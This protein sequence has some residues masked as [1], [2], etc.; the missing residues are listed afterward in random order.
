MLQEDHRIERVHG[1]VEQA[2]VVVRVGRS[3]DPEAG[4]HP[5]QADRVHGVLRPVAEPGADAAAHHDRQVGGVAVH[6][7]R[8]GELVEELVGGHQREV[9]EHDLHHH[10]HAQHGGAETEPGETALGDRGV[11]HA[12]REALDQPL[13]G[14]VGA[15]AQVGHLLAEDDRVRLPLQPAA[16][17][18]RDRVRVAHRL[19][20]RAVPGVRGTVVRGTVVRRTVDEA[21]AFQ[22]GATRA[23]AVAGRAGI[24]PQTLAHAR[25]VAFLRARRPRRLHALLGQC[26]DGLHRRVV[27]QAGLHQ[28][29]RQHARHLGAGVAV[30]LLL[31]A[32][33]EGAAGHVAGVVVAAVALALDDRRRAAVAQPAGHL[34]QQTEDG[35]RVVAVDDVAVHGVGGGAPR[36]GLHRAGVLHAGGHR[37]AVVLHEHDQRQRPEAGQVARLVEGALVDRAVADVADDHVAR[38]G[39]LLGIGGAG[40]Q[41]HAAAD[42]RVG[43]QEAGLVVAEVHGAAAP[44]AVAGRQPHDL[45][46]GAVEDLLCLC[47]QLAGRGVP[48]GRYLRLQHLGQEL[49]VGAVGGGHLVGRPQRRHRRGGGRLLADGGVHGAPDG[50]GV[51]ELQQR[52]LEAV[53]RQRVEQ[54]PRGLPAV[55][56]LDVGGV[57]LPA[58]PREGAVDRGTFHG[59]ILSPSGSRR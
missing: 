41:R 35:D 3:D 34:P 53:D 54:Q 15:A 25:R 32:V 45:S 10:A 1:G 31:A 16:G 58:L 22:L 52:V 28:D 38:S 33:A 14:P 9:R 29:A 6:V 57:G 39:E 4:E 24:G 30:L 50:A 2:D 8:L 47:R 51:L 40:R 23:H 44:A 12:V 20:R 26:V 49:V 17:H 59:F 55:E 19:Q 43:S 37:V 42:D 48:V 36:Q 21:Q 46:H 11:D 13:G 18:R 27:E 5:V 7:A 56:L